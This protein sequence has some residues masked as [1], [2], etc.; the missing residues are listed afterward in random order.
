MAEGN[1]FGKEAFLDLVKLRSQAKKRK[2]TRR[3]PERHVRGGA[4]MES[5]YLET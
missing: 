2:Q 1:A 5:A 3:E 4:G